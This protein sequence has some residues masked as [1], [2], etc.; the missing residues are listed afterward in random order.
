ALLAAH[1]LRARSLCALRL[2]RSLVHAGAGGWWLYLEEADMKTG[3]PYAAPLPADLAPYLERDL[4]VHRPRL[5]A[6]GGPR[7]RGPVAAGAAADG[8]H[9]WV[10]HYGAPLRPHAVTERV[11]RADRG[12]AGRRPL[13]APVPRRRRDQP[14]PT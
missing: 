6:A 7:G 2:G 14:G 11:G 1:P 10:T 12:A 9:A 3:G 4:A 13:A 5:L 8:D